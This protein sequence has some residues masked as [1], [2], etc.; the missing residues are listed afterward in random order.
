MK[1]LGIIL[2]ICVFAISLAAC[3]KADETAAITAAEQSMN[4]LAA[5][6]YEKI[7]AR[8]S[9]ACAAKLPPEKL[10][11]A[12]TSVT[13]PIGLFAGQKSAEVEESGG[14][15]VATVVCAFT[16][17]ELI[18]SF[19]FNRKNQ[20]EGIWFRYGTV[21]EQALESGEKWEEVKIE[22]GETSKLAGK[23]T[24]PKGVE[25]PPVVIFIQGSGASD[26]DETV[27]KAANKPFRDLAQGLAGQGIA[28]IRF[29][30]RYFE[31]PEEAKGAIT[32]E[33]EIIRD[34]TRAI[35]LAEVDP[36]V[37]NNRIYLLGHSMGGMLAPKI[38]F[39]NATVKGIVSLAGSL[40]GLEEI[41][42]DQNRAALETSELSEKE[43]EKQ[44]QALERELQKV[45]RLTTADAQK[46]TPVLGQP[47]SYWFSLNN[48]RGADY[49]PK[50][51]IPM[52][53]LQGDA[54][55]QVSVNR[56][57]Q[58]WRNALVGKSNVTYWVYGGLN[59]LFMPTT[60]AQ[61]ISDYDAENHV[62]QKVIDD[63]AKWV[64]T[65]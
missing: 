29:N 24:L 58:S 44:L 43:K 9:A 4:E 16:S 32:I 13:E 59:H 65:H 53:V 17:K 51:A 12:W 56:D 40:R 21:V 28:S 27:G 20:I 15:T 14:K 48:A 63:I 42:A 34:V 33:D 52:L 60:G 47:A 1:K 62:Q 19:T 55:F 10:E 7:T 8:M 54:D 30:K 23:L 5:G 50:L 46:S 2:L 38:A 57:Y 36:R 3:G 61:G 31:Y 35:E 6:E 45:E 18:A 26:M 39:D 49:A 25:K 37:D 64:L 41:V 22:L 11:E